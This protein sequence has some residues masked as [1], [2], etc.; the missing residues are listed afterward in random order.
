MELDK[1]IT[2]NLFEGV[3]I[4]L[5]GGG[6]GML[7][8]HGVIPFEIE[9]NNL[10]DKSI[11]YSVKSHI[12][13]SEG[14]M[15]LISQV[16]PDLLHRYGASS[17]KKCSTTF[18]KIFKN[19]V[20]YMKLFYTNLGLAYFPREDE[21]VSG[22]KTT[23]S[24][25][26]SFVEHDP[27]NEKL[28]QLFP[29][30]YEYCKTEPQSG[31]CKLQPFIFRNLSYGIHILQSSETEDFPFTLAG[32][33]SVGGDHNSANLKYWNWSGRHVKQYWV[34]KLRRNITKLSL[35]TQ[36]EL[37][38]IMNKICDKLIPDDLYIVEREDPFVLLSD[39]L[40]LLKDGFGFTNINILDLSCNSCTTLQPS[41]KRAGIDVT[42]SHPVMR[43]YRAYKNS[44]TLKQ[45]KKVNEV[46][47][48]YLINAVGKAKSNSKMTS[49]RKKSRVT[50]GGKK[51][52]RNKF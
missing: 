10:Y 41:L 25:R 23:R 6:I 11:K 37:T 35:K 14:T 16:Y 5:S 34:E 46:D 38:I 9:V 51:K 31:T 45:R 13:Y 12:T 36:E 24:R 4:N 29:N 50:V 40:T 19:I 3:N 49:S 1:K 32:I 43:E 2:P 30:P 52:K 39:I 21:F 22:K 42:T 7:G 8:M 15:K 44:T 47:F 26:N 18:N 20:Q 28:Y 17:D 48:G 33:G 27:L